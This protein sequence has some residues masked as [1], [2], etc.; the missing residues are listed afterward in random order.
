MPEDVLIQVENV[1]KKFCRSLKRALWYGVRDVATEFMCRSGHDQL[2]RGEFWAVND[3]SFAVRRGECLGLI[4]SNG[5]GKSTLLR[6]VHGLI[7]PDRG[8]ITVRGRVGG[9][10]A[11]GAG[12]NPI[13]TGR[14]NIYTNAAVL[15]VNKSV[16][17]ARFDEIVEFSEIGDAID[18]P[19]QTYSSGMQVRL[20]FAVAAVLIKPDVLLLDEVLA[21]GDIGFT[22]KCLNTVRELASDSAVVFVSHNMQFISSFCN[23]ILVLQ[24]GKVDCDADDIAIGLDAY[25]KGFPLRTQTSGTGEASIRDVK[26]RPDTQPDETADECQ[27]AHGGSLE[28]SF[29][30]ETL[31][32]NASPQIRIVIRDLSSRPI[33]TFLETHLDTDA[34]LRPGVHRIGVDIPQIDLSAGKYSF[35]IALLDRSSGRCLARVEGVAPFRVKGSQA[36]WAP[37]VRSTTYRVSESKDSLGDAAAP[38]PPTRQRRALT[39][40]RWTC[41]RVS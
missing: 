15:G 35:V 9:L 7:K 2:R 32:G 10:I 31:P 17:D 29:E 28:L 1:S 37:V 21:V 30:V 40:R 27:V 19:V 39:S 18:A 5:A 11:L 24:E 13:L 41:I 25:L 6:M 14:E 20:G 8:R 22:I 23:R 4:G 34:V 16:V 36:H 33:I 12:F 26:L 38:P 3:V